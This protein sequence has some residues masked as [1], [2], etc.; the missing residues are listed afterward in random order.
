MKN[1]LKSLIS[2]NGKILKNSFDKAAANP[3]IAQKEYLLK[4]LEQNKD[5]EYGRKYCFTKIS[6]EKDFQKNIPV[7][8]YNDMEP[9]IEKIKRGYKNILTS[10]PIYTF[11]LT[12]GTS[13]RPKFIPIT[14]RGKM[15]T[16]NLLQQWLYRALCAHP[17][18]LD[19]S[20][21]F[22]SS[23]ALEGYTSSGIPY[24]NASGMLYKILPRAMRS[25]YVLPFIVSEIQ[26]YDLRYFITARLALEKEVSFITTPNPA[27]LTKIAETGIQYQ[28]EIIRSIH[29][30][31]LPSEKISVEKKSK[32]SNVVKML[33]SYLKPN[34]VRARFLD[35]VIR[36]HGK[37]LPCRCW[38]GLK[39]IGC[40]LGG[41]SGFQADKL[42]TFYGKNLPKRDIGYMASE[43]CFTIPYEDS[44]PEGIL[45]LQNNY[46]EFIPENQIDKE[47]PQILLSHELE[48]GKVYK[49][50][51]TNENGL[52]RYD[53][54]DIVQVKDFYNGTP[55]LAFIHKSNDMLNITGEKLHMNHLIIA[56]KKIK[57]K[58]RIA[59]NHFRVV[60]N[61]KKLRF[62]ILLDVRKRVSKEYLKNI[63]LPA[64]D[65]FLSEVNIEYSSKRKSK[66]LNS[67]CLH[68]MDSKW[69][70]KAIGSGKNDVQK[71]WR[72]I[73][74][75]FGGQDKKHIKYTI[76]I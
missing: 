71:K 7:N 66:R 70:A 26:D 27:T 29:N 64:I 76:E 59:I 36:N 42:K 24:G 2:K 37:L 18:F 3:H 23:S 61:H 1:S 22:I 33:G 34:K 54:E 13:G 6:G 68:I 21:L 72:M 17:A 57:E 25:S 69:A 28:Q 38:P 41:S 51:L 15:L 11:N 73:S 10:S 35:N 67:P 53:I 20:I 56:F 8:K 14:I 19:K 39:L 47:N 74:Q 4:I 48:S 16:A 63:I 62:E 40:W 9:Y 75:E 49:I 65:N 50:I 46:Y 55:V 44:T 31:S 45:A 52:Y 30:G 32:Y 60:P 5:T 43:G 58:H 12:S